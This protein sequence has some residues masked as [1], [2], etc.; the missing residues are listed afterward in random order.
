MT[1]YTILTYAAR[2]TLTMTFLFAFVTGATIRDAMAMGLHG[3]VWCFVGM[4]LVSFSAWALLC[5]AKEKAHAAAL[6]R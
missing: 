2:L 1:K 6:A 3:A 4:L 5:F